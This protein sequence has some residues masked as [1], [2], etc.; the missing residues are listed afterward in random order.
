ME[1]KTSY[2]LLQQI[3]DRESPD[4]SLIWTSIL[5][6]F[7]TIVG[8]ITSPMLRGQKYSAIP[9]ING[10]RPWS[11]SAA[12]VKEKFEKDAGLLI[13]EGFKTVGK[14]F[15]LETNNGAFLVLS[16]E[17]ADAIKNNPDLDLPS[18][19][20]SDFYVNVPGFDLWEMVC[21]KDRLI[22]RTIKQ[23]LMNRYSA[24]Y[25]LLSGKIKDMLRSN[26]SDDTEWHEISVSQT[27]LQ[28][29]GRPSSFL[30]SGPDIYNNEE[31]IPSILTYVASTFNAATS[32]RKWPDILHP[33][34]HWFLPSCQAVRS[35]LAHC[36]SIIAP[37]IE[38]RR[39]DRQALIANGLQPQE[40]RDGIDW[41][42][43]A[44]DGQPYN[45]TAAHMTF[46]MAGILSSSHTT[47]QILY[48]ICDQ[49]KLVE[50][51]RDEIIK[52][53]SNAQ[54]DKKTFYNLK[55]MDSVMK[56]SQRLGPITMVSMNRLAL[57]DTTLVDGIKVSKGTRIV[58]SDNHLWDS[59][60]YPDADKFDGYRFLQLRNTGLSGTQFSATSP[61]T[62][63][64]GHGPWS[65]PARGFA[66]DEIKMTL[67]HML[68]NYDIKPAP[69]PK[70]KTT[71]FGFTTIPDTTGRIMVRKRRAELNI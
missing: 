71:P 58:V 7:L 22:P 6:A 41:L 16:G 35:N 42:D 30:F 32:L 70:P 9:L 61:T 33:V 55:L 24:S 13:Q 53:L 67:C 21:S 12:T 5:A 45:A 20:A 54:W 51:L 57:A 15:R 3:L 37:A 59:S 49:P 62:L 39:R 46:G 18:A 10:K 56:E 31:W 36:A 2:P 23:Y 26:W 64:F 69:G 40:G 19:T 66:S 11:L 60:L 1:N 48:D 38:Q 52:V 63:G 14:A 68:L 29:I 50:D 28:I 8:C 65:C 34:V 4:N 27:V 47:V 44:A 25:Q 17:Y 43:E